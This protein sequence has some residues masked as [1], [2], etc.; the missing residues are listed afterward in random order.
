M[1]VFFVCNSV[2]ISKEELELTE[3]VDNMTILKIHS[4]KNIVHGYIISSVR[5]VPV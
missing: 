1:C 4:F 2:E 5:I 3:K